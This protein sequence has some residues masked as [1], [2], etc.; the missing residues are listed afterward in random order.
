[1]RAQMD[2]ESATNF[3]DIFPSQ[4]ASKAA[5]LYVNCLAL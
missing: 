5:Q 3:E 4:K 1:M 2:V